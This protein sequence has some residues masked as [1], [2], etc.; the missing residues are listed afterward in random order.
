MAETKKRGRPP[1]SPELKAESQAKRKAYEK[2][3]RK[4]HPEIYCG[5]FYEPKL[6]IPI[7]NKEELLSLLASTGLSISQIFIDAVR[8][9][10]GIDLSK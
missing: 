1:L 3:Y 6:R 4:S 8:E 5:R 2:E 10:Y 9:K 7:A